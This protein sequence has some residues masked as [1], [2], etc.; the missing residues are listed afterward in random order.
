[1]AKI[2]WDSLG[3]HKFE[4]G[5]DHCVL[6]PV[7]ALGTYPNGVAWNGIT[8]VTQSPSGADATKLWADNIK[9][10]ELRAAEEFGGT[11]EAYTYPDEFAECDGSA[12]V[13]PGLRAGQQARKAFGLVYRTKIGNDTQ[14][15]SHGYMLHLIYGATCSPS[16]RSYATTNDSPEAITFSWEFSTNPV[17]FAGFQPTSYIEIDSTKFTTPEAKQKLDAL[18]AILFGTDGA[19]GEAG[20]DASLPLPDEVAATLGYVA[21][22]GG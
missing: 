20:T 9:Y 13:V 8:G 7:S 10:V 2:V 16:Q 3:S 18:E 1:M 22:V 15:D 17:N 5:V 12:T 21:P 11:I 14:L 6:Y 19:A 4:T